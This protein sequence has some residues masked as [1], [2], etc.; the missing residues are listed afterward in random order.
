MRLRAVPELDVDCTVIAPGS[1]PRRTG[2]RIKTDRRDAKML[3]EY[4]AAGRLTACFVPDKEWEVAR[5]LVRSRASLVAQVH[6]PKMH[7]LARLR[8]RGQVYRDGRPWTQKFARWLNRIQLEHENDEYVVR[9]GLNQIDFLQA[10][11]R[12]VDQQIAA[13]ADGPRFRDGVRI[14]QGFRGVALYTAMQLVCEMGDFRRFSS[15]KALMAYLGLVPSQRSSGASLRYGSITQTGNV[16][17]RKAL[18][19]AAWKYT[20]GPRVSVA[21]KRRQAHGSVRTIAIS[22]RAQKRLYQRFCHLRRSKAP[23]VAVTAIAR[24][25]AGFLWEAMQVEPA[26]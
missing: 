7:L 26:A 22:L 3:A 19:S 21:L 16:H 8:K 25:L 10:Q 13:T 18:G 4:F 5:N 12:D 23:K 24:E 15:A 11:V 2:D 1:M 17:A 6:R 14:L 20:H 9:A